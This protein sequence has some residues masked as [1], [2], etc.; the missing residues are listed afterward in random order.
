VERVI[1]S[2]TPAW[3]PDPNGQHRLRYWDGVQWTK[4]V[5]DD[6]DPFD[7]AS[8]VLVVRRRRAWAGSAF[9]Y[10]VLIDG[11]P[12]GRIANGETRTFEV[13]PGPHR[14]FVEQW[15][16][17]SRALDVSVP[18]NGE[19]RCGPR[20][21][22]GFSFGLLFVQPFRCLALEQGVERDRLSAVL[23]TLSVIAA[24]AYF[25][26]IVFF[27]HWLTTSPTVAFSTGFVVLAIYYA[28]VAVAWRRGSAQRANPAAS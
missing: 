7:E 13:S 20:S 22:W 1:G 26:V 9:A 28:I 2:T 12:A 16:T 18:P 8:N 6:R 14:V 21:N 24:I 11:Q 5:A 25:V 23:A 3:F 10:R 19:L 15:F 27:V 17:R 4:W